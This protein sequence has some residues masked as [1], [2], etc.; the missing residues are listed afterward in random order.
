MRVIIPLV[1]GLLGVTT[2]L[3]LDPRDPQRDVA[4][5]G[6]EDR[7]RDR[8]GDDRW[9]DSERD[10]DSDD[11]DDDRHRHDDKKDKKMNWKAKT[12]NPHFFN[13]V[14]DWSSCDNY[15]PECHYWWCNK[16]RSARSLPKRQEP[17]PSAAAPAPESSVPGAAAA[18]A[19][20]VAV[21]AAPLTPAVAAGAGQIFG[22]GNECKWK[23]KNYVIILNYGKVLAVPYKSWFKG[24]LATFFVDDDTRLYTVCSSLLPM[25]CESN[26]PSNT[27]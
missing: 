1:V 14:V 22:T 7:G 23:L 21:A 5:F 2:A 15:E 10:W 6:D 26:M 20:S 24:R 25:S 19:S 4:S 13:L 17:T 9:D 11:R 18:S 3:S 16:K 8:G 12:K 27:S